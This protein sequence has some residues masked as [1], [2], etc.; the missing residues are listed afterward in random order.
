MQHLVCRLFDAFRD[1][2]SSRPGRIGRA[3]VLVSVFL[4]GLVVV[5]LRRQ[6]WLGESGWLAEVVPLNHLIAIRWTVSV[7]LVFE[8]IRLILVLERSVANALS[9]QLEVYCLILLRDAFLPLETFGE[10]LEV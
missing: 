9:G 1:A 8:I 2:W 5:E 3:W 4:G 10:P 6:G 7:L